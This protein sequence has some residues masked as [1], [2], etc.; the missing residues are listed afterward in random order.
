MERGKCIL[1]LLESGLKRKGEIET[2]GGW[3][4][5]KKCYLQT[6]INIV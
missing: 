4:R 3:F 5:A 2:S 1:L 6:I